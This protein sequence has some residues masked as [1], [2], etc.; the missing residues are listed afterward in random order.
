MNK[1]NLVRFFLFFLLLGMNCNAGK[2]RPLL[3]SDEIIIQL[4]SKIEVLNS[5][6]HDFIINGKVVKSM[7]FLFVKDGKPFYCFRSACS[8]NDKTVIHIVNSEGKYDYYYYPELNIACQLPSNTKWDSSNYHEA[9]KWHF[10][11]DDSS[12]VVGEEKVNGIPCYIVKTGLSIIT[13]SKKTGMW[14]SL[15]SSSGSEKERL[16]Y[17]NFRFNLPDSFF[18]I[19]KSVKILDRDEMKSILTNKRNAESNKKD[20]TK[21][22]NDSLK[23]H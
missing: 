15:R 3:N 17:G 10:N 12:K 19:P 8:Q 23:K 11:Y 5:F 13:V 22:S 4:K 16:Y 14:T 20:T 18:T 9:K 7:D 6:G 2:L 1:S 21:T